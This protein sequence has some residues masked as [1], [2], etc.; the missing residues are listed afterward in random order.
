MW[1]GI[2]SGWDFLLEVFN[3]WSDDNCF[4]LSAA[5]SYYTLFSIAP[6]VVVVIATAGYFFGDQAISGVIFQKAYS[7]IGAQAALGLQTMVKNAY[8]GKPDSLSGLVSVG[9]LIFSAT[10]VLTALQSSLNT[11]YKVRIKADKGIIYFVLSR[12]LALL[13][14][15]VIG[16]LLVVIIVINTVWVAIGSYLSKFLAGYSVYLVEAGELVIS[17]GTTTLLFAIIFKYLPDATVRWKNVW[18]GA[19]TTS[20]LFLIGRNII[21]FYLGNTNV[22]SLYGA[23]GSIIILIIWINYSSWMFFLGAEVVMVVTKRNGEKVKPSRIAETYRH[24]V[25]MHDSW[26]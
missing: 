7:V 23:A 12:L 5:L 3:E 14:L 13:M 2:K 25:E 17:L 8:I 22:T 21:S 15:L 18:I 6:L 4:R 1:K 16:V 19:M 24:V 11:I 9:V 26:N 10:V 20:V